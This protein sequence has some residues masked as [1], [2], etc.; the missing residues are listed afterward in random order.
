LYSV[1]VSGGQRA[2]AIMLSPHAEE[3]LRRLTEV[4]ITKEKVMETI[5][6]PDKVEPSYYGRKIAQSTLTDELVLRVVFEERDKNI[7]VITIY[8]GERRRYE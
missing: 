3:K 4:G 8:P 6:R 7:L 2:L 1:K 5:L